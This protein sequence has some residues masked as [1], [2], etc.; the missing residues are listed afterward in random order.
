[1][2]RI[3]ATQGKGIASRILS[4]VMAV[5]LAVGLLPAGGTL[6]VPD[7][8][9]AAPVDYSGYAPYQ[10][11]QGATVDG[12]DGG[13]TFT[14]TLTEPL[15]QGVSSSQGDTSDV[16]RVVTDT[17]K[18]VADTGDP[19]A[20]AYYYNIIVDP[21]AHDQAIVLGF[22]FY[23]PGANHVSAENSAPYLHV[24]TTPDPSQWSEA[25][26]VWSAQAG[27][28]GNLTAE[29]TIEW[30]SYLE[31]TIPAGTLTDGQTYYFVVE[32][33]LYTSQA[34]RY[35]N[36]DV[37]FEFTTDQTKTPEWGEGG[38]DQMVA[39]TGTQGLAANVTMTEGAEDILTNFTRGAAYNCWYNVFSSDLA[40]SSD[41]G[42]SFS[43]ELAGGNSKH[44][45]LK[46][47][48]RYSM[49]YV[50]VYSDLSF[51]EA[52]GGQDASVAFD[53]TDLVA[54]WDGGQ[55]A[56][57]FAGTFETGT[58]VTATI[59]PE[60][61]ES[62]ST[63]YLVFEPSFAIDA[64]TQLGRPVIFEFT[65]SLEG[66]AQPQ[67][68][69]YRQADGY[70][71]Y[72]GWQGSAWYDSDDA[73]YDSPG[74][75]A[76]H[77]AG[78]P[79]WTLTTPLSLGA[80]GYSGGAVSTGSKV[81]V[82][83]DENASSTSA[84]AGRY[85]VPQAT[86]ENPLYYKNIVLD[87]V[88]LDG[89]VSFTFSYVGAGGASSSYLFGE[90]GG[91]GIA[92]SDDPAVWESDASSIV[93]EADADSTTIENCSSNWWK[94][95]TV[96]VPAG[97]LAEDGTYYLYIKNGTAGQFA[98]VW[99]DIVFEFTT[100]ADA[101]RT[102]EGD[103][104]QAAYESAQGTGDAKVGFLSP[105]PASITV[106]LETIGSCYRNSAEQALPVGED[107]TV[108]MRLYVDGSGSNF[109]TSLADWND[110]A[111]LAV[112]AQDPSSGGSFS[113]DG[114]TP[115]ASRELG[116]LGFS[117]PDAEIQAAWEAWDEGGRQGDEPRS[118]LAFS[119]V[120]A[121]ISGLSAGTYYLVVPRDLTFA[122]VGFIDKPVVL[123]FSLAG[124]PA[125]EWD[126]SQAQD[127]SVIASVI[128]N[129]DGTTLTLEFEG[130]GAMASYESAADAPWAEVYGEAITEASIGDGVTSI[131]SYALALP[132]L[133]SVRAGDAVAAVEDNAFQ[134]AASLAGIDLSASSLS[135][136]G[137]NAFG[138]GDGSSAA[139]RTV[140]VKDE[141]SA[142]AVRS[143]YTS[144]GRDGTALA[145]MN[146]GSFAAGT[147][148][149]SGAVA[150]PALDGAAFVSWCTDPD[151]MHP[152][153]APYWRS[154]G[155]DVTL[156][157]HFEQIP[158][159]DEPQEYEG[160]QGLDQRVTLYDP[161]ALPQNVIEPDIL[162]YG[163]DE[164]HYDNRFTVP[165][166]EGEDIDFAFG[167]RRG[168]NAEGGDGTYQIS[169]CLPYIS[170]LDSAGN[171]VAAYEDGNGLL[172]LYEIVFDNTA[173]ATHG[174][175]I[176]A[177]HIGVDAG[178]LEPG[179]YTL[180]FGSGFG[181]NNGI[182][183]LGTD[184]DF[185]FEVVETQAYTL[186]Y[187]FD[188]QSGSASVTGIVVNAEDP[189]AVEVPSE[190]MDPETGTAVPVT[191]VAEDAF[192]GANVSSIDVPASVASIGDGAFSGIDSL[193]RVIVRAEGAGAP[194][195]GDGVFDGSGECLLYGHAAGTCA[196][197]A[198]RYANVE[199]RALD[200]GVY[201]D[202]VEVSD[203]DSIE[204]SAEDPAAT[205]EVIRDG[206]FISSSYRGYLT[207]TNVATHPTTG[208][209]GWN[210][211]TAIAN[212]EAELIIRPN[213]G[214][215]PMALR[216][217]ASGFSSQAGT[218]LT[219]ITGQYQGNGTNVALLDAGS[220]LTVGYDESLEY[221]DNRLVS[222]VPVVGALFILDFGGPGASWGHADAGW[223]WEAFL[224]NVDSCISLVDDQGTP[225]A[226][227][228]EGLTIVGLPER[229]ATVRFI[230]DDGV[231][232]PGATY[233][234]VVSEDMTGH[235]VAAPLFK[236]AHWTFTACKADLSGEGFR[237][238][239][240]DPASAEWAGVP[241]EPDVTVEAEVPAT[242][243]WD[244][245]SLTEV[246]TEAAWRQLEEGVDYTLSY[247][248]NDGVTPEG[249]H[250]SV[251]VTGV[252][253]YAGSVVR[254]FQ[255][256][257]PPADT[258]ELSRAIEDAN[259]FKAGI[260]PSE[261]G[262]ELAPGTVWATP[263]NLALL[264]QA[265]DEAVAVR[266]AQGIAQAQ[267]D[268]ATAALEAA[269][270]AFRSGSLN[271]AAPSNA[272]LVGRIEAISS[273]LESY[274]R[275]EDG[276][277]IRDGHQWITDADADSFAAQL[278]AARAAADR[279]D[280]TQDDLDEALALLN[281]H[282][283]AFVAQTVKTATVD[284]DAL[285]SAVEEA[286]AQRD[287]AYVSDDGSDVY[288]TE[289][290][291]TSEELS[292]LSSAIE[293]A[294]AE[295][296]LAAP[297]QD[298]I[299]A[300]T[301]ALSTS[302][303][304]FRAALKQGLLPDPR[305]LSQAIG[306]ASE[307]LESVASSEDGSGLAPG[308]SWAS[309][310]AVDAFREA[311]RAA[312]AVLADRDSAQA[313]FDA[314]SVALAEAREA[315]LSAVNTVPVPEQGSG[316]GTQQAKHSAGGAAGQALSPTGDSQAVYPLVAV[317]LAALV[318]LAVARRAGR[319]GAAGRR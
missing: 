65:A 28:G 195:W 133:R 31:S 143:G 246:A 33:G 89:D 24:Y 224:A 5:V 137:A 48:Q 76:D 241:I 242:A 265:I 82:V 285:Q 167:M 193:E 317:A 147:V 267:A 283:D 218:D 216:I 27:A 41:A 12:R 258:T 56:L 128:P 255:I 209:F 183:F 180:R 245:E 159:V 126:A 138:D 232:D 32:H 295:L 192:R 302:L 123:E 20:P 134:G 262:S 266:D 132:N 17:S 169:F 102:W 95:V 220:V 85:G 52:S 25:T 15:S 43:F 260:V 112:Y 154:M 292:A 298:E 168:T 121:D 289:Q 36:A 287:A 301:A 294:R 93:W 40:Y 207:N 49:P 291:V 296:G 152:L 131:G 55:G 80:T 199:F 101:V 314:A 230:V 103:L 254:Y 92:T 30:T 203:G 290:W 205:V 229:P 277:D 181:A 239:Q 206:A 248:D 62:G 311:I 256:S 162:F 223:N 227:P 305:A 122:N 150:T 59:D 57:S 236:A 174:T 53:E 135:S 191:A 37:V 87:P 306:A 189:V 144:E 196:Q 219:D 10:G 98:R 157:A 44:Q 99:A 14:V 264:Q 119:G 29:N 309:P 94:N 197:Q 23:G 11:G 177:V 105:D 50:K 158:D 18:Q 198:Q 58:S 279:Q 238:S 280:A 7:K 166:D 273:A 116:N 310:E 114:L 176:T 136:V 204:L 272:L 173:G 1:M 271:A 63:Y 9:Y 146:G 130:E 38:S 251:I 42:V 281:G 221:F 165:F 155:E 163:Q 278:D 79:G 243:I 175:T 115:V 35:L 161:D 45:D 164:N 81:T 3:E 160:Y 172:R 275:S 109:Q 247:T 61:L 77:R 54:Q 318:A 297:T 185:R 319:R 288:T 104:S 16:R 72:Q 211:I 304:A 110:G 13:E 252:G 313:D 210:E 26:C 60:A 286:V 21:L 184:V 316:S 270:A 68:T 129:P 226:T 212:G 300:A 117:H 315:F 39:Y 170:I 202:G 250:A 67:E 269:V 171:T 249:S 124:A 244:Q 86:Y 233:T 190:V 182:S 71:P 100:D 83:T 153:S 282:W 234:L 148:F 215:E 74:G 88:S 90:A 127:G 6:A 75:G 97:T 235:N 178:T 179:T 253:D 257:E 96:T 307:L 268:A 106:D 84:D 78:W 284:R 156:Y 261:D 125:M 312:Q 22:D 51:V 308:S 237:V 259:A 214:G 120:Q 34:N 228:G 263:A 187:S 186:S 66:G 188:E 151:L 47:W 149:E 201:A 217:V 73:F 200:D 194:A 142:S 4:L 46:S 108:S 208:S 141:A 64:E 274:E 293:A 139:K 107:G 8:A 2:N 118:E 213:D 140:Y 222:E 276:S 225:V 240:P 69:V 19:E 299:D 145:V 231:M 303:D 111:E 70:E 91:I 113:V